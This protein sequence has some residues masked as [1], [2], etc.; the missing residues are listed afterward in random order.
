MTGLTSRQAAERFAADGRNDVPLGRVIGWPS[1]LASQLTDTVILVL[2]AAAALTAAVGD[3]PDMT[4]IAAVI[5]INTLLGASQEVRSGRALAALA[6]LTAPRATVVRDGLPRD[7]D[8]REVVR[9]DVIQLAA[10]DVIAADATVCDVESLLVDESMLTGESIPTRKRVSEPVF[11]GTVVTRGRAHAVVTAVGRQTAIGGI[12]RGL[13]DSDRVL[14]PLQ[15]QL[16]TLGRRLAVGVS[17]AAVLVAVL[18][19][20]AGRGVETSV[21]LAISLAVAAI[22][23]S[24]PA[25]MRFRSPWPLGAWLLGVCWRGVWRR[26]RRSDR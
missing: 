3:L 15:R 25:V 20:A 19:L 21:V 17:V 12:A 26:S 10:G 22:P 14:T 8:A 9:G 7:I 6:D 2:L 5:V 13:R 11:A 18:N 4:V 23:E 24:L 1:A 16:A